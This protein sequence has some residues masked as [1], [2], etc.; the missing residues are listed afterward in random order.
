MA[1]VE[2]D[3]DAAAL[4]ADV[5]DG[6][7]IALRDVADIALVQRLDTVASVGTKQGDTDLPFNHVFPLVGGWMP[8]E[9]AQAV[10]LQVEDDTRD[11]FRDGE[12]VGADPPLAT[13]L[14]DGMRLLIEHPV[15]MSIRRRCERPL[16]VRRDCLGGNRTTSAVNF[17]FGEAFESRFGQLE[18]LREEMFGRVAD[19]VGDAECAKFRE[20]AVVEDEDEM[21]RLVPETF[22]HVTVTAGEVPDVAGL[23]I[24][25][26][27]T[28]P[29]VDH[30][31]AHAAFYDKRPFGSRGV[32]VQLAHGA[33]LQP[34]RDARDPLGDRQLFDGRLLAV[35]AADH[36][37]L[38]LLQLELEGGQLD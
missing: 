5:L 37:T 27:G 34:H 11:R 16:M 22:E 8:V 32:P 28:P 19:P 18:V 30:G 35:A 15:A 25:G 23:E 20:V 21:S 12:T 3:Q 36:P 2:T 29:R 1:C 26:L 7:A 4:A 24:V 38:R 9:L 10:G 13:A 6:M 31:R 17:L 33:R 14:V